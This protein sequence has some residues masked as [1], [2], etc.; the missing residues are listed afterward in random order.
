MKRAIL[1]LFC[2]Y[3]LASEGRHA[4]AQKTTDI[5]SG[6]TDA[7]IA[8]LKFRNI[9]PAFMSG[10][11]ADIAIHPQN[12]NEWYV[13][14]GSGGVWKTSNA[15]NTW[16]SL[17]DGQAVYS[18]GC[19]TIDPS[20]AHTVWVG[21][22]ENVG[23]RHVGFGD[24]IYRSTDD[25]ATWKNMGLKKSEH[26]SKII[27]H[28]TNS[29]VVFVAS[30][31]P[32]WASGGERGF[33][34]TTDGGKSW[35]RTLG[36]DLWTGVTDIAMDLRNPNLLYA[37][38][39][40]RHRTV[41]A[42]MG[43]G[44]ESAVYKSEDGG[45]TWVKL[46][47][48]LPTGYIGKCGI[49][50]SPQQPDVL[51]VAVE[52]ERRKGAV[53]KSTNK[54]ESWS[55]MSDAISGGTGPHYYQELY[56]SPHQFDKIYLCDVR[57]QVSEDG[58]KTF[59]AMSEEFKH[60]DNHSIAFLADD[61]NYMLVGTDGGIYQT[62][63]NTRNW[64]YIANL[65]ITQ[66]YKIAVDDSAPFYQIY[67]GT[68]DNSTQAG[69][70]RTVNE[71]GISNADWEIVLF[72]D[73]HQPATEPNN[74]NIMYAEW[75]EGNL[76]R[77]DRTTGEITYIQPQPGQGESYERF[78]W[79][80][81]ILVSPHSPTRLYF[82]S[83]R[84]WCS[85]NR[86]DAWIVIS[87]DLTQFQDR[88][89]MSIMGKKHSWDAPWDVYAM[90]TYNTITSLAESPLQEGL[91]YAGTDDG[92]IQ[93]SE[94]GGKNW[95]KVP[96]LALP[97]AP[98]KA[99]VND[100][101]ADLHN[102]ATV[103][104][105][106]DNHKNGDFSPYIYKSTD[107]GRTWTS[108]VAN[109]PKPLM[110]WRMVQDHVNP[111]LLF[112]G[113]EF[114]VYTSV[115]GGAK[116][117]K[118]N[119]GANI[120]VR[121]LAIQRRENDLVAGSF[122][123]G[124]FILDDYSALRNISENELKKSAL[125]FAPRKA[126]WYLERTPLGGDIKGSQGNAFF[127]AANPAFGANFTYYLRDDL[128]TL[129][130]IRLEKE[131]EMAKNGQQVEFPGWQALDNESL[132]ANLKVFLAI[133]KTNGDLVKYIDASTKKGVHLINWDLTYYSSLPIRLGQNVQNWGGRGYMVAP[134]TYKAVLCKEENGNIT[135]L[136]DTV[137]VLV[138][139]LQHGALGKTDAQAV[140]AFWKELSDFQSRI[141]IMQIELSDAKAR[142]IAMQ[143][144]LV[145]SNNK[146]PGLVKQIADYKTN[147]DKLERRLNGSPSKA[148]VGEKDVPNLG[149]RFRYAVM[150][151]RM[152]T[153]GPNASH[154][155]A[156]RL[157]KI[158]LDEVNKIL[159]E[160]IDTNEPAIVKALK[161]AGAPYIQSI[162]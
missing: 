8:D 115:D 42:Y 3:L 57:V 122:G 16:T 47:N 138:E 127:T 18:T 155:E 70:S 27:V 95:R 114:G 10:R 9:G 156:M 64:N 97:G 14:V 72:A 39:W 20:N 134:G 13:A 73:G 32:L 113:T 158:E 24:G 59:K 6:L 25:G 125:L 124:I 152:S 112:I 110:V 86:G 118:M 94:D 5:Q 92:A 50:I 91:L 49:A 162:K 69:P 106:L 137:A 65:P 147:L 55:K 154:R 140:A 84:V 139:Q 111:K 123:R 93:V 44:T 101:K 74:P 37:V 77:I 88:L 4:L 107:K 40:Q 128:K 58:G 146:L 48:G 17:F 133:Y 108:L 129:K 130:E 63:D 149:D 103:Y 61:P 143:R 79:D 15:G 41:A 132:Q 75:Q 36:D 21:T 148:E 71:N 89:S 159:K 31:G 46:S 153:A 104:V 99:F 96:V 51:Y 11:I 80:A 45:D 30:Q 34:K 126:W 68:Q 117:L 2:M 83:H 22:G 33:Y 119:L 60:S 82:A 150:G 35:K 135:A 43:G 26:I 100:I 121:D 102:V 98:E 105:C 145:A 28:P 87:P 56:A 90:S 38:T 157:A 141:S 23:G 120:S 76:V 53:Y 52:L 85:D 81:P 151:T 29:N 136:S 7:T 1:L 12:R 144:A 62:F 78:N 66:F 131:K 116:W 160:L 67:G 142:A 19:V 161:D 109:L 54:G